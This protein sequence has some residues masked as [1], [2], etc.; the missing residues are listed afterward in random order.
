MEPSRICFFVKLLKK[1][2]QTKNKSLKIV[3]QTVTC[4]GF[5]LLLTEEIRNISG[6]G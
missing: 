3:I 2:K 1:N 4:L 6:N 5:F